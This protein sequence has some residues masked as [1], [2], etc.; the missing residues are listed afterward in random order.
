MATKDSKIHAAG[1]IN[2]DSD[3]PTLDD[4]DIDDPIKGVLS[5]LAKNS[6]DINNQKSA[7]LT[8]YTQL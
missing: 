1:F 6:K 2:E 3:G 8:M 7:A 4:K 5:S